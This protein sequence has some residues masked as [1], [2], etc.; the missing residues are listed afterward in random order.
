[1]EH[2]KNAGTCKTD[3][4]VVALL[5]VTTLGGLYIVNRHLNASAESD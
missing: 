5:K 2:R 3:E 1:M 4:R